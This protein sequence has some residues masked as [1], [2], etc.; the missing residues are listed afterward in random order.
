ME[1]ITSAGA[2]FGEGLLRM[3]YLVSPSQ[4]TFHKLEDVPQYIPDAAP[5]FFGMLL[6]ETA[7]TSLKAKRERNDNESTSTTSKRSSSRAKA[8]KP[9]IKQRP[10]RL[11]D[12]IT[13]VSSGLIQQLSHLVMKNIELASY[14]YVYEHFRLIP[15]LDVTQLWVWVITFLGVDMGYYWFHRAA[16]EINVAWAAHSVHH[17]SEEYNLSTA[18]RQSV[19]QAYFSWVFY[20]PLALFVPPP[21]YATHMSLNTLYQFWIHTDLVPNLGWAEYILN[22]PT[23]HKIHHAR[24]PEYI[25]KNYAGVLIIWDRMFGTYQGETRPAL[26]GLTHPLNSFDLF[27]VQIAHFTHIAKTVYATPGISHKLAVLFAGPGWTPQ[28]PHLRLGDINDIP[29]VPNLLE[30][31]DIE[32]KVYNPHLLNVRSN[33]DHILTG[34][35]SLY[36]LAHF[37]SIILAELIIMTFTSH[38]PSS[39][40]TTTAVWL[41]YSLWVL[42]GILDSKKRVYFLEVVRLALFTP[43]L[44]RYVVSGMPTDPLLMVVDPKVVSAYGLSTVLVVDLFAVSSL[45]F[46]LACAVI[47]FVAPVPADSAGVAEAIMEP[48]KTSEPT[49]IEGLR[50]LFYLVAPSESTFHKLE[51]VPQY[52]PEAAPYFLGI[53]L[54]EATI[55]SLKARRERNTTS[56]SKSSSKA[57]KIKPKIKQRPARLNDTIT[58]ISSGLIQ[59]LPELFFKN[60][61]LATYI[62]VYDHFRII[63]V[64][65]TQLWVW[66]ITFLSVDMAYYWLHRMSHEINIAWAAHFVHHSSEDYNLSAAFRHSAFQPYFSWVFNLPM[67]IFIPPAM[68]WTHMSLNTLFQFWVHTNL[69]VPNLGWLEY[70]INTPTAHRIHHGRNPEYIDKNYAGVLI[71]WDRMFGTYQGETRPA[72]YG[73][74]HPLNS[75][76]LFRVQ[77][78]HFTHIAKTVYATP[79]ISHKLAVLFAGPGWTPQKPHLR[80]GDIND[81]PEVPNLLETPDTEIK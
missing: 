47:G 48:G 8:I 81:I 1:S 52:I 58:S 18:L 66:I 38:I 35:M 2:K 65:V 44:G 53:L 62:Y 40:I 79:G 34:L 13:S 10:A 76:D 77:F 72:V 80:L 50:R 28:K 29:E 31:P 30:T 49:F 5:Y 45:A 68:F 17:S 21:M 12:T 43:W 54:F 4:S 26:Y 60:F 55:T 51:D 24:N 23:A 74:T 59:Q 20:L 9:K 22:T 19:F 57:T 6:I 36:V 46:F 41:V 32:I 67:A 16:H 39:I 78:G 33:G 71:I 15:N 75:F 11:N 37:V 73:L 42:S 7:I 56:S 69:P 70:I 25:D 64:D 3:F 14:I 27:W 63:D 61:E